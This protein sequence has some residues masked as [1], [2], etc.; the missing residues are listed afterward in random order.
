MSLPNTRNI[1]YTPGV[2]KVR[3]VDMN[4]IQDC[5]VALSAGQGAIVARDQ[6]IGK[7]L[8]LGIWIDTFGASTILDDQANG[9]IGSLQT[10]ALGTDIR[11]RR[12][13]IGTR[14][15]TMRARLRNTGPLTGGVHLGLRGLGGSGTLTF[16]INSVTNP[17]NWIVEVDGALQVPNGTGFAYSSTY[18]DF[19]IKRKSN[20]VTFKINGVAFHTLASY[21]SA[22]NDA[23]LAIQTGNSTILILDFIELVLF[24]F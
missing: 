13:N 11:T 12:F 4:D 1:T 3:A 7:S 24:A 14:D 10:D 19:E 21:T 8:N 23:Y 5:I 16:R 15:F 17:T 9:G 2:T 22:F 20:V 6:F 18:A